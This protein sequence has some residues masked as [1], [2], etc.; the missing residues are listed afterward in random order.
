[1]FEEPLLDKIELIQELN[2]MG[3]ETPRLYKL[4]FMHNNCGGFCFKAGM[5]HF[6]L[7]LEKMPERYKYHEEKEQA[8]IKKIFDKKWKKS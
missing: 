1:M 8:L 4:G 3:I 2:N 7:L 6:K 5:G